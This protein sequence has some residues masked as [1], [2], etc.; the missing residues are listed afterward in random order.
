M[1]PGKP[2][3]AQSPQAKGL[4]GGPILALTDI[5]CQCFDWLSGGALS[6]TQLSHTQSGMGT[7]LMDFQTSALGFEVTSP[8]LT[9]NSNPSAL[10]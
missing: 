9:S 3:S 5:G 4:Q 7:C 2:Q 6:L 1:A 8:S 10:H